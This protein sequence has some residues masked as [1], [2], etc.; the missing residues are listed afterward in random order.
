[1][2]KDFNGWSLENIGKGSVVT[3][4]IIEYVNDKETWERICYID[5][6]YT[7]LDPRQESTDLYSKFEFDNIKD[8]L[9]FYLT[10]FVSDQC[11]D[12]KFWEQIYVNGEMVLE[13]YIEPQSTVIY[14][15]RQSINHDMAKKFNKIEEEKRKLEKENKI[16]DDFIKRFKIN[17]KFNDYYKNYQNDMN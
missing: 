3:K 11:Y 16:Y 7:E 15:L 9:T 17:D 4:Y 1:M 10:W 6:H 14:Y 5:E 13:Q 12:I 2:H 8:A